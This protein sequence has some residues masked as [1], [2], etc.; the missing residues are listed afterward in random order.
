MGSCLFPANT[1]QV[2]VVLVMGDDVV[3]GINVALPAYLVPV[4]NVHCR[5]KTRHPL[6][7]CVVLGGLPVPNK[8]VVS[9]GL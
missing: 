1:Q 2:E 7:Q 8:D 3:H 4:Q 9:R 6:P 5:S